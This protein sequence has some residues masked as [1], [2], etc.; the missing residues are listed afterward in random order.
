MMNKITTLKD[1]NARVFSHMKRG[2]RTNFFLSPDALRAEIDEGRMSFTEN[3]GFLALYLRRDGFSRLYYYDNGGEP[4]FSDAPEELICESVDPL[5]PF[6]TSCGFRPLIF[7][8][9]L[10]RESGGTLSPSD[11]PSDRTIS[12]RGLQVDEAVSA[13]RLLCD[14][15]SPRTAALPTET[16]LLSDCASDRVLGAFVDGTLCGLLRLSETAKKGE[17]RH[18][19]VD[20]A[21][22]GKGIAKALCA[23]FVA[24]RSD[25]TLSV[26]TGEE[27]LAARSLYTSFGFLPD[28]KR[29]TVYTRE[30][31]N[32]KRITDNR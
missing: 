32:R 19:C 17:I 15:F 29:A 18:L 22:R 5:P 11:R 31:E 2:V 24:S 12:V 4:T 25:K 23:E 6:L 16:E 10:S 1:L 3:D 26:W 21:Y 27:N 13:F 8:V 9:L 14:G 20:A 7:R 28:G 30:A